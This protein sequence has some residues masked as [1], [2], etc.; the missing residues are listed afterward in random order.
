M[1]ATAAGMVCDYCG[2]RREQVR[3]VI[4]AT[5]SDPLEAN[6]CM[7][8]GTGKVSCDDVRCWAKGRDEGA[9]AIARHCGKI[10]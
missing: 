6:W 9:A 7:N 5:R 3:F 2:K 10:D 4:G 8:E 1:S